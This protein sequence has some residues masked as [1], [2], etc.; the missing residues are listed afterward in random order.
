M[1]WID[2]V[3]RKSDGRS[4]LAGKLSPSLIDNNI[5]WSIAKQYW[6]KNY[7]LRKNPLF[8]GGPKLTGGVPGGKVPGIIADEDE[9]VVELTD[10]GAP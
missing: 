10:G 9:K 1:A 4:I 6:H 7:H 3:E 8:G 2:W 5:S